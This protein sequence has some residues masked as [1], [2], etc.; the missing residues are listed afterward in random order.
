ML[1]AIGLTTSDSK[2]VKNSIV[3]FYIR[4][5]KCAGIGNIILTSTIALRQQHFE[6]GFKRLRA[7]KRGKSMTDE[8][9]S[10]SCLHQLFFL[11][12]IEKR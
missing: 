2:Q 5:K 1:N 9:F 6:G 12:P 7:G 11:S 3:S 4:H 8:Q 10:D